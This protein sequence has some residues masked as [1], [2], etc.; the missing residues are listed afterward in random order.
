[1]HDGADVVGHVKVLDFGRG[2]Q[3]KAV[4]ALGPN[5]LPVNSNVIIAVE[6]VLHV[7]KA[8][9]MNKLVYDG[10][11]PKA[12]RL[13]AV[14]LK[15]DSLRSSAPPHHSC[16]AHRVAG[17]ENEVG[18]GGAARK[19]QARLALEIGRRLVYVINLLTIY[20]KLHKRR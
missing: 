16:T 15:A 10:E 14:W 18:L 8:Q 2:T 17:D 13:D 7:M 6:S 9:R 4:D 1:M 12:A 20:E 3:L 19:L 11:E 5:V